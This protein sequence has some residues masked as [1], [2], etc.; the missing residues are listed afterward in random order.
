MVD[1]GRQVGESKANVETT[2][3]R[4]TAGRTGR[5]SR[6]PSFELRQTNPNKPMRPKTFSVN[7]IPGKES[8][9]TPDSDL[10]CYQ[11]LTAI[12]GPISEE[13]GSARQSRWPLSRL[14]CDRTLGGLWDL[15]FMGHP[16]G[17]S[18]GFARQAG[19]SLEIREIMSCVLPAVPKTWEG[20]W[21]G[22]RHRLGRT[23]FEVWGSGFAEGIAERASVFSESRTSNPE[24][25]AGEAG[26]RRLRYQCLRLETESDGLCNEDYLRGHLTPGETWWR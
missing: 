26:C 23:G 12:S 11:L 13:F 25:P 6:I 20:R 24:P 9:R 3:H 2:L 15:E 5:E 16:N 17:G 4:G 22:L 19:M 10:P 14:R 18:Q 21:L 1:R 7:D 8:E